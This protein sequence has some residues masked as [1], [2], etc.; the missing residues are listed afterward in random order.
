MFGVITDIID[1][2]QCGYPAIKKDYHVTG[3]ESVKCEWCGYSHLKTI[4]EN[5]YRKGYGSVHSTPK[6]INGSN[7]KI[8]II[9]FNSETMQDEKNNY[10]SN[11]NYCNVF[12]W[13]EEKNILECLKGKL[14]ETLEEIYEQQRQ[15]GE[16]Y[17]LMRE[18]SSFTSSLDEESKF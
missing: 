12:V 4:K 18:Y 2:P 13:N 1:C 6:I 11:D 10:I 8:N 9:L 16:Y 15:E 5:H 3:E 17:Q 7:Q 14:P